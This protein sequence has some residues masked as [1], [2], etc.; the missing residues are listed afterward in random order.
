MQ[1]Q[2]TR[3]IEDA[4]SGSQAREVYELVEKRKGGFAKEII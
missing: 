4:G 2:H 3:H 1:M